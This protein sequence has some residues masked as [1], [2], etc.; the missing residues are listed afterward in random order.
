MNKLLL[1]L[2]VSL[3]AASVAQAAAVVSNVSYTATSI[4]FTQTGDL[5]GYSAPG[6][7]SDQFGV[8]YN[9]NLITVPNYQANNLSGHLLASDAFGFTGNT[10][11]FGQPVAYTW[12]SELNANQAFS[13]SA[14]TISWAN[15]EL[16]TAGTGR[17]D[18]IWGNGYGGPNTYTVLNSVEVVRGVVQG[19]N[20][21]PEPVSI[22]LVGAALV[23]MGFARKRKQ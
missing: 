10:G 14:F 17:L 3:G 7:A 4:T 9:G 22:A 18:F 1:A 19:Q 5:T 23:G 20:E 21:L 8:V 12:L 2:A 13:G 6:G 11:Y 15:T 16:N